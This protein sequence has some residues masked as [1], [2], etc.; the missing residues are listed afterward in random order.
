MPALNREERVL[1]FRRLLLKF[2]SRSS[3]FLVSFSFRMLFAEEHCERAEKKKKGGRR[4]VDLRVQ[5]GNE[6]AVKERLS[7]KLLRVF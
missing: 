7:P 3:Y 1:G 2:F 6:A 4:R 5:P